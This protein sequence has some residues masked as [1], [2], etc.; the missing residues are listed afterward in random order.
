MKE[1]EVPWLGKVPAHW[2]IQRQ[3]SVAKLIVSNVDKHVVNDE[4]PV[5][6]CNYVDV[7]K[8]DHI[9]DRI[10]FMRATA[11]EKEI[12]RFHLELGDVI[13]TKDSEEWDDIG[14]PALIEY[15]PP[16]LL[17][18]YH[19][20]ILRPNTALISGR[21][22]LRALQSRCVSY[23][24]HVSA[25][26]VTR[27]GIS[28]EAIKSVRIPVPP[29]DEQRA[30][31]GFLDYF[32]G[33]IQSHILAKQKSIALLNEMKQAIVNGVITHGADPK[34]HLKP[35]GL[36]WFGNVPADWDVAPAKYHYREV[37]ERSASGT[38]ELLSVLHITGV[39]PRSEK[40]VTMF[41]AE[42]Y[43]G[44]KLCRTGDLVINTMWAWM[45]ALGVTS[46]TGIVSPSYGV[47]RPLRASQLLP[48][49]A[50]Q[51]LR[52]LPYISEYLARST[53]IR[54]SRLRL[55]PEQFLRI[56][57]VCPPP[58]EQEDILRKIDSATVEL[59]KA[60]EN[61]TRQIALLREYR[62]RMITDVATG[63]LDLRSL[64]RNLPEE[65]IKIEKHN[66]VGV[67]MNSQGDGEDELEEA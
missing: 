34:Q 22:L 61:K 51:L 14:V 49:F 55:Y 64:A 41:M 8:N 9:T 4:V 25:N 13:I 44:H 15:A 56:P 27:Y 59:N 53:G 48:R 11:S 58:A 45:G 36:E 50:D 60:M 7:Y 35:S 54:S 20:A 16:D 57:L 65:P 30:I 32:D 46:M 47:Y 1:S 3:R 2:E 10:R 66:E 6:L 23:Q 43:M 67:D 21:Y 18:G 19:L 5:R 26:G 17:C 39:T 37:D 12:Q 31:V 28:H 40:N 63:K 38:E 29:L 52:S 24:F 62:L 33:L 42:S